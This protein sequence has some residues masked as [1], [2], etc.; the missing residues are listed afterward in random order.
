MERSK[1]VSKEQKKFEESSIQY[2]LGS[3]KLKQRRREFYLKLTFN[4]LRSLK[5]L[6]AIKINNSG[7]S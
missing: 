6:L 1:R 5:E 4:F 7:N 2:L 3:N